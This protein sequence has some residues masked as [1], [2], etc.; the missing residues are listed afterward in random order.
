MN[1]GASKEEKSR[2]LVMLSRQS[3]RSSEGESLD[4]AVP[5]SKLA[6]SVVLQ[7]PLPSFGPVFHLYG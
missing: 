2:A 1:S 7:T 6:V 5:V 4:T 3:W